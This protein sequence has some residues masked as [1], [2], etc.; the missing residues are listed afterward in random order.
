MERLVLDAAP[1][2]ARGVVIRPA[3]V[4]GRGGGMAMSFVRS[5]REH[6]AARMVGDGNN[7]WT[8]VHVDDLADLYVRLL[9]APAG[10]LVL[11]ASGPAVRVREVAEAA[12]R[13]AGAG[14]KVEA[15]PLEQAR[16][17]L[18]PYADALALDQQVT[19]R[20]AAE[21]PG[22]RP[23]ARRVLDEIASGS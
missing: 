17:N 14:G 10:T 20:R 18:G 3:M 6:G 1:R 13:A 8:W 9:D 11:A 19:A 21:L 7:R 2:G 5:A 23:E 4:Y 12:S 16:A 15:T 22:W